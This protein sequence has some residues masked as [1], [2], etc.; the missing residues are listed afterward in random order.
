MATCLKPV[1]VLILQRH[2]SKSGLRSKY[3]IFSGGWISEPF[4]SISCQKTRLDTADG[5]RKGPFFPSRS[6]AYYIAWP[7]E[8]T[9]SFSQNKKGAS[10]LQRWIRWGGRRKERKRKDK[11][12]HF[13]WHWVTCSCTI[14]EWGQSG[15]ISHPLHGWTECQASESLQLKAGEIGGYVF[16]RRV[17]RSIGKRGEEGHLLKAHN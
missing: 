2:H 4:T 16:R 6:W 13:S 1:E 14:A 9:Y 3:L 12:A 8:C 15:K 10:Q 7:G 11:P 5:R 17:R